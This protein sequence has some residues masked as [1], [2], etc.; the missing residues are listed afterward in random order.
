MIFKVSKKIF[1]QDDKILIKSTLL[2]IV[3]SSYFLGFFLRENIAGGAEG[4]FLNHTWPLIKNFEFSFF[5][6]I[7]NYGKFGEGSWPMFHILNAYFNPLTHSQIFFQFSITLISLFNFL[8]FENIIRDKYSLK[9]IDSLLFAS[10]IL[11][12]P[13]FRSSSFWGINENIGW[14]FLLLA[15]KYYFKIPFYAKEKKLESTTVINVFLLCFFSSLALYTRQYLIFFSIFFILD[16][17][18]IKKNFKIFY[19]SLV[20]FIPFSIP[21]LMLINIWGGFYDSSNFTG[22]LVQDYHHPK[23]IL[24]NLPFLFSFFAFYLIPFLI[25]EIKEFGINRIF[26]KYYLSFSIYFVIIFILIF[27]NFFDFLK[28]L[29]IGGG[30]F[31]KIDYLIFNKNLMFF[32]FMSSLGFSILYRIIKQD[33]KFNLILFFTLFI[34]C[35]PKFILQEYYEPLVIFLYFLLFK[36]SLDFVFKRNINFSQFIIISYFTLYLLGS[37]YYR[38]FLFI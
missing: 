9:R 5:E 27:L 3:F 4:D 18:I 35:F 14:L 10:I 33:N 16:L 7:K 30:A 24:R 6:T 11:L 32:A 38:Y 22:N 8:I 29:K 2:F 21:G 36:H 13:F 23:Y 12:L 26:K 28:D 17:L 15:I 34:F 37:F 19:L 25:L 20:F 31:L 1:M